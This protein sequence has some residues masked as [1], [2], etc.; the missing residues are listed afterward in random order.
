VESDGPLLIFLLPQVLMAFSHSIVIKLIYFELSDVIKTCVFILL[1]IEYCVCQ[2]VD[3]GTGTDHRDSDSFGS[4]RYK[5]V[6]EH[7]LTVGRDLR[8]GKP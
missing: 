3:P 7:M 8:N 1:F 4:G 5:M 2:Q 6:S